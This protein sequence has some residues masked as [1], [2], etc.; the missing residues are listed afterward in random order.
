MSVPTPARGYGA[1]WLL[2]RST[3]AHFF[4]AKSFEHDGADIGGTYPSSPLLPGINS[5]SPTWDTD[6]L[7]QRRPRLSSTNRPPACWMQALL[8]CRQWRR[9]RAPIEARSTIFPT[10][11]PKARHSA[12]TRR[13]KFDAAFA[14]LPAHPCRGR[15]TERATA[16]KRKPSAALSRPA[17][18]PGN[19]PQSPPV[20][21][22]NQVREPADPFL[23]R[24]PSTN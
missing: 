1:F 21:R 18:A 16:R 23:P 24:H 17:G 19:N 6:Q 12:V 11:S 9:S 5:R 4:R 22:C 20:R 15:R 10:Q 13:V 3:I 7:R 14:S 8:A 2:R